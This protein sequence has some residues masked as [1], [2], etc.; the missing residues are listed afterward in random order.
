MKKVH[1]TITFLLV[2][3]PDIYWFKKNS[4][5][6]SNKPFLIWLL[7]TPAH[8]KYIA[9][10]PCSLSFMACFTDINVSQGSV[11]TYARYGGIFNIHLTTNLPCNLLVKFFLNQFR[12][13]RIVTMSVWPHFFGSPCIWCSSSPKLLQILARTCKRETL[14]IARAGF[15]VPVALRYC[16]SSVVT[17]FICHPY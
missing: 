14:K 9:T 17:P 1:D 15:R 16:T 3:L 5:T 4:L 10:L 2:T 6:L 13:D 11:A 7:I 8:L 12:F